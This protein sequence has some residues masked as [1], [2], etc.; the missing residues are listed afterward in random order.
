MVTAVSTCEP[1]DFREAIVVRVSLV[2]CETM[3]LC[4]SDTAWC[5][6]FSFA[7]NDSFHVLLRPV[8][9][10]CSKAWASRNA[11]TKRHRCSILASAEA[12]Q[13]TKV[14]GLGSVGLD[15]LA[16]V[17]NFPKPDEKIRTTR[18]EVVP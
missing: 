9:R 13:P 18:M 8:R 2:A 15:Y 11:R 17:V 7:A 10:R 1:A 12:K 4:T 6:S 14:V 5:S 16:Q 3:T